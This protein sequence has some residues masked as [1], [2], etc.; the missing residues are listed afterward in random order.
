M[1][2]NF[3]T[4]IGVVLTVIRE[5]LDR[6]LYSRKYR[7]RNDLKLHLGCGDNIKKGWVNIDFFYTKADLLIDLR[8]KLPFSTGSCAIIYSHH[9]LEHLGYPEP[10][11][12]FLKECYRILKPGGIFDV[13]VPDAEQGIRAYFEEDGAEFFR[14]IGGQ[15][16]AEWCNTRMEHINYRFRQDGE[17]LFAYDFET[18]KYCL[19]KQGFKEVKRRDFDREMDS[20]E[21]APY[22]LYVTAI[23]PVA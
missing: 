12:S 22:T 17:H 1:T 18:L 5:I 2:P 10:A 14:L 6:R 7:S 23:K 19:E 3:Y 11:N 21:L 16:H 13:G 8:K 9:F 15:N 20:E 4:A